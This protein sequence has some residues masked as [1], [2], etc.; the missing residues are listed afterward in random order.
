MIRLHV[1]CEGQTEQMF[2]NSVLSPVLQLRSISLTSSR[3]GKPG[4]KGGRVKF[5]RLLYDIRTLILNDVELYCTTLFDYYGLPPDFPG[6]QESRAMNAIE[7]KAMCVQEQ[8]AK[9][10]EQN[11]EEVAMRR[12]IPYVQMHEFEGLLFSDTASFATVIDHQNLVHDLDRI[13]SECET[14][15]HIN[16]GQLTAPSKRILDLYP[17]F[18]KVTHGIMASKR[19]GIGKI[20]EECRLFDAWVTRLESLDS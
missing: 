13:R 5:D 14:P 11:I 19:I 16:D 8:L 18:Q 4:H 9:R 17:G 6:L 3:I 12:F 10:L 20:R 7:N 1:I 2:V 15:E